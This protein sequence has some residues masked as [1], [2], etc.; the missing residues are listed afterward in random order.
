MRADEEHAAAPVPEPRIGVEE[1]GRAVQRDDR[2]AGAGTTVDD[3]CPTRPGSDDGV[4]VGLDGAQHVAHPGRTAPAEGGDEGRLVVERRGV[5]QSLLGERL[6]PVVDDPAA[7][8]AVAAPAHQ[9]L[10]VRVRGGEERLGGRRAP[11]D[12]QPAAVGVGEPEPTDVRR[13]SSPVLVVDDAAQA[14]VE[15]V[16][17]QRAQPGGQPVH[18]LV[19]LQGG[20]AVAHGGPP[21]LRQALLEVGDRALEPARDPGEVLPV[22]VDEGRVG[23]GREG[24]GRAKGAVSGRCRGVWWCPAASRRAVWSLT[25]ALR[26]AP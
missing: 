25:G 20:L 4:L 3:Q 11:V 17:A 24:A 5:G 7:D 26:Q 12:E 18:L 14:E 19:A 21:R 1:V 13:P 8:P 22:A 10:R 9:A 15:V 2:L 16:A 6:V 23:L